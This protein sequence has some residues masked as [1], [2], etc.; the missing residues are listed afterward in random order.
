MSFPLTLTSSCGT[1]RCHV[2]RAER[3]LDGFPPPWRTNDTIYLSVNAITVG[4]H[5]ISRSRPLHAPSLTLEPSRPVNNPQEGEKG[6]D[7]KRSK[8]NISLSMTLSGGFS[9]IYC[10]TR[11][12][13]K[14]VYIMEESITTAAQN[15][16]LQVDRNISKHLSGCLYKTGMIKVKV[17]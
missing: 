11:L 15:T 7:F 14:T 4:C 1:I 13:L 17:L 10:M 16:G 12:N 3:A 6:R 2:S 9:L 8:T 5:S